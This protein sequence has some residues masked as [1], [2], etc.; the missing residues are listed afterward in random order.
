MSVQYSESTEAKAGGVVPPVKPK[1][2]PNNVP[3][4]LQINLFVSAATQ[5]KLKEN[6]I[7]V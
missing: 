3:A 7:T 6:D 1:F 2:C 4:A 5:T